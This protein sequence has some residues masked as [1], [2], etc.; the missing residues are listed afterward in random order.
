[1]ERRPNPWKIASTVL[2]LAGGALVI[3]SLFLPWYSFSSST[4]FS[5]STTRDQAT[6]LLGGN[7][8]LACSSRSDCPWSSTGTFPDG[9]AHFGHLGALYAGLQT[10]VLVTA[11]LALAAAALVWMPL[12]RGRRTWVAPAVAVLGGVIGA[13]AVLGLSA[14]GPTSF[15][16]DLQD[17]GPGPWSSFAGSA[18]SGQVSY[19]WGPLDGWYLGLGAAVLLLAGFA[20]LEADRRR[21]S[22]PSPVPRTVKPPT[23]SPG[24]ARSE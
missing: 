21:R 4:S 22:P 5:G 8:V 6:F 19:A 9:A 2:L 14:T 3:A 10:V 16:A 12:D 20:L 23:P 13:A 7:V 18:T 17:S 24:P 11:L 1:V 15:A